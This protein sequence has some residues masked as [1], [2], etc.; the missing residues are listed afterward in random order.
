LGVDTVQAVVAVGCNDMAFV[1]DDLHFAGATI[2]EIANAMLEM[3][4]C[5]PGA[6]IDPVAAKTAILVLA[7][8][9]AGFRRRAS[10]GA[11]A[12]DIMGALDR[13]GLHPI[14]IVSALCQNG[15][16]D[17]PDMERLIGDLGGPEVVRL[18]CDSRGK[19]IA[20]PKPD[21][22]GA[23]LSKL[24]LVL[25]GLLRGGLVACRI[26]AGLP[27]GAFIAKDFDLGRSPG[28]T[29]LPN[30]LT[31][32]WDITLIGCPDLETIGRGL[33]ANGDMN[34]RVCPKWDGRIPA[35]AV[36][37]GDILTDAHLNGITLGRW[38]ELHP[39]GEHAMGSG[40]AVTP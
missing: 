31:V 30:G 34:I 28:L 16:L 11:D 33:L 4:L 3:F 32:G 24:R 14:C 27:D 10:G 21:G 5:E 23:D 2:G 35:D 9:G 26:D 7:A 20:W 8:I 37:C 39:D 15:D 19:V 29:A 22:V 40:M 25:G 17:I 36:I 13:W 1:F 18:T 12:E 6:T 38:K